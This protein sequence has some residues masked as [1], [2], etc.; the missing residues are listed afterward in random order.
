M[1]ALLADGSGAAVSVESVMPEMR[2]AVGA[3][4]LDRF[5]RRPDGLVL[6]KI[7]RRDAAAIVEEDTDVGTKD[8][9]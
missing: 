4:L 3:E 9:W 6:A 7:D 5:R 8:P 2:E 1:G